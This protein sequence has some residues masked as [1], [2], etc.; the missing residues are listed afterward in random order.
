MTIIDKDAGFHQSI[1]KQKSLIYYIM[2]LDGG[3]IWILN[4]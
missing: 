1:N 4:S 2:E 3:D